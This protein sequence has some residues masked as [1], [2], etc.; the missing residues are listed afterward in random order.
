MR[1]I[2]STIE[3]GGMPKTKV[4]YRASLSYTQLKYYEDFLQS[5]GLITITDQLWTVTE[6]GERYLQACKLA[7]EILNVPLPA[8]NDEM[9]LIPSA[10]KN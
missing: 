2:L 10:K 5:S 9:D 8:P 1:D 3:L 4:M 6:K 7:D